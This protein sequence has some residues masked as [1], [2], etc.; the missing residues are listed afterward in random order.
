[1]TSIATKDEFNEEKTKKAL[2]SR[3]L[4]SDFSGKERTAEEISEIANTK[5]EIDFMLEVHCVYRGRLYDSDYIDEISYFDYPASVKKAV[6]LFISEVQPMIQKY[7]KRKKRKCIVRSLWGEFGDIPMNPE[8]E[9]IEIEWHGFP[10]GT[11]REEI[12]HWFENT[13]QVSVAEDLMN[14]ERRKI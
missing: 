13:F 4:D 8:T 2:I 6:K 5:G 3:I 9:C 1:M 12:W 14:C 11:H 7:Y 10:A